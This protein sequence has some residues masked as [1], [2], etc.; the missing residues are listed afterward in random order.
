MLFFI[1]N[2]H[3]TNIIIKINLY[4]NDLNDLYD[5]INIIC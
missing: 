1:Y 3:S 2:N 4:L 5:K